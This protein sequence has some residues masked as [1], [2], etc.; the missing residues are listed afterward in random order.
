VTS[1]QVAVAE[2]IGELRLAEAEH[3]FSVAGIPGRLV[4]SSR[5]KMQGRSQSFRHSGPS[6]QSLT[7][8]WT[9]DARANGSHQILPCPARCVCSCTLGTCIRRLVSACGQDRAL[10]RLRS[11]TWMR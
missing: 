8:Q 7:A 6:E 1:L 4:E 3:G 11:R 5:R 10:L 2:G 9:R